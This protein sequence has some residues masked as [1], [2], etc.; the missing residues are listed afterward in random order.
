MKIV[1]IS[2]THIKSGSIIGVLPDELITLIKK[3]DMLIHAGDFITKEVF[4]ELSGIAVLEGVHGNMDEPELK[5]MLPERKVIEVEGIRIGIIHQA[6][7]SIQDSTGARYMA[8][9][10]GADVLVF[11]HIHKP[12]VERS[13]VLLVCPGSPTSPRSSQPAAVELVIEQGRISGKIITFPGGCCS[14][15]ENAYSCW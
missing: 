11:G 12:V 6:A 8:K 4:D 10:M 5:R 7:L 1:V 3:A 15:L 13:D 2:D 14:V 9:E